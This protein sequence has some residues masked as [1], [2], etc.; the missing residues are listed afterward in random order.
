MLEGKV[1]FIDQQGIAYGTSFNINKTETAMERTRG[2]LGRSELA[3]DEGLWISPCNSIHTFGMGY[4][5][6][7]V[8]LNRKKQVKKITPNL[9]P[10]RLS[11]SL[12]AASVIEFKAGTTER[13]PLKKGDTIQW[14]ENV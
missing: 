4:A 14:V 2:L 9:K 3:D 8:Y 10:R 5:L 12:L 7:I 13:L 1:Q 11:F 6:D